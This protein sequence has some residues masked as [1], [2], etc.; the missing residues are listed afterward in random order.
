MQLGTDAGFQDVEY[1][2]RGPME[3]Y[4]DRNYGSD[5][6]VY[7]QDLAVFAESYVVPQEFANRTDVRW[8]Y[9]GQPEIKE[10]ITDCGRQFTK[11]EYLAIY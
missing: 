10:W 6:G 4:I 11:Y 7:K 8:F 9:L 3:N 1:F 5:I 2:G